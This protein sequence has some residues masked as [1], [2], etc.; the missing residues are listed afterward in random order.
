MHV[1]V[2][3]VMTALATMEVILLGKIM[4]K[5]AMKE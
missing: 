5:L 1:S 3:R 4:V 2:R